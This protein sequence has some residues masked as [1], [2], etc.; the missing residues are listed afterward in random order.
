MSTPH[1]HFMDINHVTL[2]YMV[3]GAYVHGGLFRLL[4]R[5]C[6]E[7]NL[8]YVMKV[9]GSRSPSRFTHLQPAEGL[10]IGKESFSVADPG[11]SWGGANSQSRCA[12]ILF[13]NFFHRE[14]HENE[15]I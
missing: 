1:S 6:K 9:P 2:P 14:L 10:I 4:H 12:N 5:I 3:R 8:K 7:M 11:F 15:R 13:C